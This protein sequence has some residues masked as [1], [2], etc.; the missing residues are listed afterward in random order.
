MRIIQFSNFHDQS[1]TIP[2]KVFRFHFFILFCLCATLFS[3]SQY[4]QYICNEKFY[5]IFFPLLSFLFSFINIR[6]ETDT[7]NSHIRSFL[8]TSLCTCAC[9]N[10]IFKIT[11]MKL[12]TKLN[13]NHLLEFNYK[14]IAFLL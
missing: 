4:F 2:D 5:F 9:S 14:I 13:V 11:R 8:C 1:V 10:G 6:I 3:I 12:S 7:S